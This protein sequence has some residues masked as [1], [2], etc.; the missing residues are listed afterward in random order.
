MTEITADKRDGPEHDHE[1]DLLIVGAGPV[2][3]ALALALRGSGLRILL[4]DARSAATIAADPRVLA[5]SHGTRTTLEAFGVWEALAADTTPITRIH[6][7]QQG[8]FGRTL[9]TAE[10]HALD[11]VGY[12]TSAGR[13]AA[14]LRHAVEVAGIAII[15][16]TRVDTLPAAKPETDSG[17]TTLAANTVGD[18]IRVALTSA[19]ASPARDKAP[20]PRRTSTCSARL[21][22]RAE[23]GLSDREPGVTHHDYGQH[24]LIAHVLAEGAPTGQAFERFTAEGPV[25]LLPYHDGYALVHVGPPQ[26]VAEWLKQSESSYLA[27]LQGIVGSRLRL[28]SVRDR[29]AYPLGLRYRN[30]ITATRT[31]WLG[32]AAQT[33]HPVAGQGFNLAL[34]DVHALAHTLLRNVSDPGDAALLA[35]YVRARRLDRAGTIRFTDGLIRVF[36]ND[37]APLRH[38][39]GAGLLALDLIAPMRSFVARR[40]MFGARAWP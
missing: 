33:L 28:R 31:V 4:A 34:R 24:A 22:A 29:I 7:S 16:A 20:L 27:E 36:G 15:D 30:A 38:A 32:N 14:V 11:A 39:R 1:T 10:E 6:V 12:V 3:L 35:T 8:G 9:I 5:L 19:S 13:L 37:F 23:G 2:G 40:M 25:A 26:R 17:R 18:R 21:V